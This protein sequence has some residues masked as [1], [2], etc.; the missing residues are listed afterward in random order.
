MKYNTFH[1][2]TKTIRAL[3]DPPFLVFGFDTESKKMLL[4]GNWLDDSRSVRVRFSGNGS[5]Y[6]RSKS[7]IRGIRS[8]GGILTED[9][10]YI[11]KGQMMDEFMAASFP[12]TEAEP[13]HGSADEGGDYES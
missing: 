4:V 3:G 13:V 8:L 11:V 5:C 7:L 2:H 1:I 9:I 10:S 12:L 6:I